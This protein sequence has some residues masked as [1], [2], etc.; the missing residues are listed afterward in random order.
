VPVVASEAEAQRSV[1]AKAA[2]K[3]NG[4]ILPRGRPKI[5]SLPYLPQEVR[6]KQNGIAVKTQ[7]KLDRLARDFPEMCRL[8]AEGHLTVAAAERAAG[9]RKDDTPLPL[10]QKAWRKASPAE[11]QQICAWIK[12]QP[13]K[14]RHNILYLSAE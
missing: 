1:I 14:P 6:A 4:K 10:V 8:V 9:I 7:K 3:T 5:G 11:R 12:D 13:I 2:A